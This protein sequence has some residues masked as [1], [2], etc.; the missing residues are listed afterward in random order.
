MK[1]LATAHGVG[2]FWSTDGMTYHPQMKTFMKLE[3]K[4]SFLGFLYLGYPEGEWPQPTRRKPQ[5]HYT[6]WIEK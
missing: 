2:A 3:E 4:D 6:N 1:L 5:E